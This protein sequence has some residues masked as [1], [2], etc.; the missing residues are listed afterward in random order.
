[1]TEEYTDFIGVYEGCVPKKLCKD[2]IEAHTKLNL[3]GDT[4]AGTTG[5]GVNKQN[6][7]SIDVDI[8]RFTKYENLVGE[9]NTYM[10][11]AYD[12]Y[13]DKYFYVDSLQAHKISAY[14][15]QKYPKEE[16]SGYFSYHCESNNMMNSHRA[17]VYILYLNDV[18]KGG[19]T[20]FIYQNTRL[21][22]K[23]G[24]VVYFPPAW[25]HTH[26]GNPVFSNEDKYIMTGW[27]EYG[28]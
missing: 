23:Q 22:P 13:R 21:Q 20:E 19:E 15:V 16:K 10:Q 6:K 7:N 25:T 12:L 4:W 18:S 28:C 5:S 9:L 1:M 26:R 27:L 11:N 2:I 17:M 8:S 14:Q 3:K 24:T